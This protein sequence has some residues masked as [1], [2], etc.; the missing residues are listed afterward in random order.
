MRKSSPSSSCP[1]LLYP[2]PSQQTHTLTPI[3]PALFQPPTSFAERRVSTSKTITG[4]GPGSYSLPDSE[5]L[6]PS[7]LAPSGPDSILARSM[8]MRR[9]SPREIS[10]RLFRDV[11]PVPM[12]S[13]TR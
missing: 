8:S 10:G 3:S 2:E 13:F 9:M 7:T 4:P 12:I 11:S 6:S 1:K 5:A